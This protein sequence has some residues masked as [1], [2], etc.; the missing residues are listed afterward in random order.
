MNA[1]DETITD[2]K[3]GS[4]SLY[5]FM[6]DHQHS[7]PFMSFRFISVRQPYEVD[8]YGTSSFN[9]SAWRVGRY[10]FVSLFDLVCGVRSFA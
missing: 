4:K 5:H 9:A 10:V 1:S 6:I 7:T 3:V 2:W 8:A